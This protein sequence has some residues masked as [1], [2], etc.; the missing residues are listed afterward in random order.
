M[1]DKQLEALARKNAAKVSAP[2]GKRRLYDATLEATRATEDEDDE[3][4]KRF[5][6]EMRTREF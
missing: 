6:K 4:R 1:D 3:E 5:F 2:K